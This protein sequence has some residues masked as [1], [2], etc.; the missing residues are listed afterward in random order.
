MEVLV[1][2]LKAH[3]KSEDYRC[4]LS[5]CCHAIEKLCERN[6]SNV[7]MLKSLNII[8]VLHHEVTV[9][10]KKYNALNALR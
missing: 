3:G 4:T 9:E 7:A 6:A 1:D 2:V 8:H 5:E 10:C